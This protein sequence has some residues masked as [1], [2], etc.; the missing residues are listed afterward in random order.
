MV[1]EAAC[2]RH[3]GAPADHTTNVGL[4]LLVVA[5]VNVRNQT[6]TAHASV[7]SPVDKCLEP[8]LLNRWANPVLCF[9]LTL[10]ASQEGR[11]FE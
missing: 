7:R 4:F 11:D 3:I 1:A 6:G 9:I 5:V 2:R 10:V 8:Y